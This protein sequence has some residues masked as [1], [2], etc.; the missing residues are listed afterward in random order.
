MKNLGILLH[1]D[2]NIFLSLTEDVKV[3]QTQF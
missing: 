2:W 1:I 3:N